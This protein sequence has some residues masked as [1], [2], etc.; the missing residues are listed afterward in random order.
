MERIYL[1]KPHKIIVK[2]RLVEITNRFNFHFHDSYVYI[3]SK[4]IDE[5]Y[6]YKYDDTFEYYKR[7]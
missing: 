6:V 5:K 1:K 3:V 2:G 7:R 4:N